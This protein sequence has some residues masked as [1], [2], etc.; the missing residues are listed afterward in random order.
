MLNKYLIN[1]CSKLFRKHYGFHYQKQRCNPVL[2]SL[3]PD[4]SIWI[5]GGFFSVLYHGIDSVKTTYYKKQTLNI[6]NV[7]ISQCI[8]AMRIIGKHLLK[9]K[10]KTL[11]STSNMY[12]LWIKCHRCLQ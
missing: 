9:K 3:S 4:S 5:I 10:K 11:L 1:G 12:S 2:G 8:S 6:F 7:Y